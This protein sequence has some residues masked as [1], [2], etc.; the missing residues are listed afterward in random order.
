M[1]VRRK[2]SSPERIANG[3]RDTRAPRLTV[4]K[5]NE[6]CLNAEDPETIQRRTIAV[7]AY[8]TEGYIFAPPRC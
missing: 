3:H 5:L 7:A 2:V 1:L 8:R 6:V 4:V